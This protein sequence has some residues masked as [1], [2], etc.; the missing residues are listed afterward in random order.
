VEDH[1]CRIKS[2]SGEGMGPSG[3]IETLIGEKKDL[4]NGRI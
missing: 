3:E 2:I 4:L 1:G